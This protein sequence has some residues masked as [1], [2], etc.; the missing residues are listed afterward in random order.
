MN[1]QLE[2]LTDS[3]RKY[4]KDLFPE[5]ALH[6]LNLHTLLNTIS[7]ILRTGGQCRSMESKYPRHLTAYHHLKLLDKVGIIGLKFTGR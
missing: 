6:E 4:I 2:E 1:T 5:Q 3:Q 7:W